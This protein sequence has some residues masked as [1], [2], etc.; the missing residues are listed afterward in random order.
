MQG[1]SRQAVHTFYQTRMAKISGLC[2][3]ILWI[4]TPFSQ[5]LLG[6]KSK[7]YMP[8]WILV[9]LKMSLLLKHI[10]LALVLYG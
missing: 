7:E 9:N 3:K 6:R 8:V 2:I 10:V 5:M 4:W 1:V